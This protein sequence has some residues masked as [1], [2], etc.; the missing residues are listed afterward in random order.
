MLKSQI[1]VVWTNPGFLHLHPEQSDG[2]RKVHEQVFRLRFELD[3]VFKRAELKNP[4][5]K[6]HV[7]VTG[8]CFCN[9]AVCKIS[10]LLDRL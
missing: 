8:C 5:S 10:S 1:C 6:E 2:S 4:V 3:F 7:I 9:K